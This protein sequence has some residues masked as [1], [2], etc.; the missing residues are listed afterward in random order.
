VLYH[1][2]HSASPVFC[3]VHFKDRVL[4]SIFWGCL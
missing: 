2:S 3:V 1:V 4:R